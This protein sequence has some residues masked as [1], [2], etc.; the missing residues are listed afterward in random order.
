MARA[1]ALLIARI[2]IVLY[3][4]E[5]LVN[6]TRPNRQPGE[7]ALSIFYKPPP[8]V[9]KLMKNFS[10]G[11]SISK[12]MAVPT[13]VFWLVLAGI[14]AAVLVQ[15]FAA[16]TKP[17]DRR[18]VALTWLTVGCLLLPF[19]LL[20]VV[21]VFEFFPAALACV[22]GTAFVLLLLRGSVRFAR[23]PLGALL[24]AFGWG[25]LI[26]FSLGRVFS[27]L[28]SAT[29]FD[30]FSPTA[31]SDPTHLLDNMDRMLMAITVHLSLVNTIG[32]AGGVALL[33]ALFRYRITD[34][35]TGLI[36]GASMGLGYAFVDSLMYIKIY[37]SLGGI[38][39]STGGFE[40]WIRQSVGLL[41]GQV[42]FGA[43][44]GA[45][46]CL[47]AR[48]QQRRRLLA[49][50]AL[51]TAFGGGTA[52]EVLSGWLA[53]QL[54]HSSGGAVDT[55]VVSPLL[56]LLPQL[57]FVA[58][59]VALLVRGMRERGSV[60]R[61]ALAQEAEAGPAVTAG[62]TSVLGAPALRLWTLVGAWRRHGRATA[63]ALYRLQSAQLE[64]AG[65]RAQEDPPDTAQAEQAVLRANVMTLKGIRA[66][67]A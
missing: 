7:G 2:V 52:A 60:L 50:A 22:P 11:D 5:L 64:L 12:I 46:L 20:S 24:A 63:L 4:V 65:S 36:L 19:G 17:N 3:F 47:A 29:M 56:W 34:A 44:L 18:A 43:L 42:T 51:V 58:L 41:G 1:R 6:L 23:V 53:G 35:L 30:Y 49:V 66:V 9:A 54:Q 39:G 67:T 57:P 32:L 48:A 38:L 14:A 26:V 16:I 61:A 15:V 40:Y 45:G 8:D 13:V 28:A 33:L 25:A 21:V 62:E 27:N 10:F 59:A 37:G 31:S 55:L